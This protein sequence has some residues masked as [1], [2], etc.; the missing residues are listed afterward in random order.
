[1]AAH[2]SVVVRDAS[3]VF[4]GDASGHGDPWVGA[5]SEGGVQVDGRA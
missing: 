4:L 2:E 5:R 3:T 1:M